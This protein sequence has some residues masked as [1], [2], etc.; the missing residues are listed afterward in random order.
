MPMTR[1]AGRCWASATA[2]A[3]DPVHRSTITDG[4]VSRC[5]AAHCQ[6]GLGLR[7][8]YEHAGAD[9]QRHRPERRR[10]GEMLQRHSLRTRGHDV[11]VAPEEFVAGRLEQG[12]SAAFGAH[13]MSGQLLGVV[14]RGIDPGFGELRRSGVDRAPQRG[15]ACCSRDCLSAALSAS[16]NASRSP[17]S[18]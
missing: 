4:A 12:Q 8:R 18:T 3:P 17:S 10:P 15:H 13:Q 7:A 6:H 2:N 11:A 16:N 5:A 1:A 9:V 14:T